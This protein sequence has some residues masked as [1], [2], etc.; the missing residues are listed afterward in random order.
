MT[1]SLTESPGPI[2]RMELG[3]FK[4]GDPDCYDETDSAWFEA[5]MPPLWA[6]PVADHPIMPKCPHC[7]SVSSP[8]HLVRLVDR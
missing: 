8:A 1:S 4:C 5:E 6:D 2:I 7:L 3:I